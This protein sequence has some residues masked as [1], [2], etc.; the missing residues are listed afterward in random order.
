MA[1]IFISY[2]RDDTA[3]DAGRIYDGLTANLG[4]VQV[5]R[6]V[7]SGIQPGL[8][9]ANE[10][11]REL[12]SCA[13]LLAVIG[14][15]WLANVNGVRRIEQP[16]DY[17]RLEVATGLSRGIRVIPTLVRGASVPQGE[18]LPEDLANLP[19]LQAHTMRDDAW[20]SDFRQLLEVL[21]RLLGVSAV[22]RGFEQLA[23]LMRTPAIREVAANYRA[24]FAGATEQI[25]MLSN[26]KTTHD[27]L[28]E[29]QFHVFSQLVHDSRKAAVDP[30]VWE[31][32][33]TYLATLD[34]KT[35][36]IREA[37]T[38]AAAG[39]ADLVWIKH[40]ENAVE[41][42]RA[43]LDDQQPERLKLVVELLNRVL[44]IQPPRI[45]GALVATVR[46]LRLPALRQA[47]TSLRNSLAQL[48]LEADQLEPFD[49]AVTE[50]EKLGEG[51]ALMVRDHDMWQAIESEL[52]L[53]ED[54][55]VV[56]VPGKAD[57]T[58]AEGWPMLKGMVEPLYADSED[59][60]AVALQSDARQIDAALA[61]TDARRSRGFFR[62]FRHR[63]GQRFFQVDGRLKQH[64]DE[65]Q[66]VGSSIARVVEMSQ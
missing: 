57:S 59:G 2:R 37:A 45:N 50:L 31:S 44:T 1:G 19:Q 48:Q 41:Q 9:W 64:C 66:R 53:I 17:V 20:D 8:K 21:E 61:A 54:T 33:P 51:L 40:L 62:S 46:A 47:M 39:P 11:E 65:L 43:A 12:T 23:E 5:F 14:P 28:H 63:A 24:T 26:L 13:V 27:L 16:D 6:D 36:A 25:Q 4:S 42:L 15:Q 55:L 29:L 3:Q 30:D 18:H 22:G 49:E 52:R 60:W 32:V 58:L 35:S 34:N 10:L 7:S 38:G 56:E